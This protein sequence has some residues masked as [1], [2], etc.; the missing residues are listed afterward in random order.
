MRYCGRLINGEVI[1]PTNLDDDTHTFRLGKRIDKSLSLFFHPLILWTLYILFWL[2][3]GAGEVIPG[4][5][6]GI[7]GCCLYSRLPL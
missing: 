1:D 4:W 3:A 6:I 7:L 2:A 5:D